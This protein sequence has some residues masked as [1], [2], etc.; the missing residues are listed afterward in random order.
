MLVSLVQPM[1][2]VLSDFTDGQSLTLSKFL[3]SWKQQLRWVMLPVISI[4]LVK[5]MGSFALFGLV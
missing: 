5:L 1:K 4:F 3:K 2:V